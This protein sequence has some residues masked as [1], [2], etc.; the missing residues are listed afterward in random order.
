MKNDEIKNILIFGSEGS[1]KTSF[2]DTLVNND[3]K[4]ILEEKKH[5]RIVET[6]ID[7]SKYRI[8]DLVGANDLI[9]AADEPRAKEELISLADKLKSGI[10]HFLILN[11]ETP[12]V[13]SKTKE[14][15]FYEL[16][17]DEDFVKA[18]HTTFVNNNFADFRDQDAQDRE[19]QDLLDD[20]ETPNYLKE[21]IMK[22]KFLL[23]NSLSA[24]QKESNR[25]L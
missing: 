5:Y 3:D 16:F 9:S 18:D 13:S 11:N 21:L 4:K 23:I 6:T 7:D 15:I 19:I 22:N 10:N 24:D 25:I 12:V 14:Q 20:S 1:E 17:I 8:I 2:F